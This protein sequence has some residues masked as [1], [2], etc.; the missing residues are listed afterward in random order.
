MM[1]I[2]PIP[3][4]P[5]ATGATPPTAPLLVTAASGATPARLP[6]RLAIT[7]VCNAT[8]PEP[9]VDAARTMPPP[10]LAP[11]PPASGWLEKD[12]KGVGPAPPVPPLQ[13]I[14][15]SCGRG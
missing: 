3:A 5:A 4:P 11:D 8:P 1:P 9:G 10:P 7:G 13:N 14:D 15:V 6:V 12:E 2:P